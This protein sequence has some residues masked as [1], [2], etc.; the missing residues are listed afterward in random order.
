MRAFNLILC[1]ALLGAVWS[2]EAADVLATTA[3]G[4]HTWQVDESAATSQMCCYS[5]DSG[6][7]SRGACNLD[8][9]NMSFSND[10]DCS[11]APGTMQVYAQMKNG[12]PQ[13]I[14]VLSSNCPVSTQT[15]VVDHGT[16]TSEQNMGW[17]REV[18]EDRAMD[19]D[20]REIALF[21]LVLSESDAAYDYIDRLLS[22]N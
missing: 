13:E 20:A 10:G 6:K 16:V 18:I 8:G 12:K 2:S 14:Y 15:T 22:L 9:R 1:C 3:D 5:W 11:T 17:F 7:R 19:Q 21:A 4:W